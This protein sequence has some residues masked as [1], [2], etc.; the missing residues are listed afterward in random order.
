MLDRIATL[1]NEGLQYTHTAGLLQQIANILNIVQQP[2]MKEEGG[3]N[4]AIDAIC[5]LLQSHKEAPKAA[6]ET[7]EC[8][9]AT[10]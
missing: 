4:A 8:Q 1:F 9:N 6:C 3:K 2:Y 5:A 10:S 7:K